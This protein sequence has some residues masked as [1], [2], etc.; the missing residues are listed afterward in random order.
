MWDQRILKKQEQLI[1][2]FFILP[3]TVSFCAV[4][5]TRIES[6]H[7]G[8]LYEQL[9]PVA[10]SWEEIGLALG[11]KEYEIK[12]IKANPTLL[13]NAPRSYL[14]D[15]LGSWSHWAPG[16]ARGS[17][18]FATLEALKSAVSRAGFGDIALKLTIG[19]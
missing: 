10:N 16:D 9:I 11:F 17:E 18:D 15:M 6:Y 12:N 14:S 8:H 3:S 2:D 19:T 4:G 5:S 1:H 7:F 13:I